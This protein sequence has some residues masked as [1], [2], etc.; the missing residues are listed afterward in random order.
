MTAHTPAKIA[1]TPVE[2]DWNG[3]DDEQP[4]EEDSEDE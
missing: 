1:A 2:I 4:E 3:I